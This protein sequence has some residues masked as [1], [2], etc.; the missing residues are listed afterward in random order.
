MVT[1]DDA[2]HGMKLD[3]RLLDDMILPHRS[4]LRRCVRIPSMC[5]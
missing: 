2:L 5:V 4:I 3:S 1:M